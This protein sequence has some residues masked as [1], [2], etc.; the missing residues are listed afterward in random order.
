MSSLDI[1]WN[2]ILEIEGIFFKF[3]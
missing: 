1:I 3:L 2:Y